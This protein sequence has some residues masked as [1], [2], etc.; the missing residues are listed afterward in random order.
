MGGDTTASLTGLRNGAITLLQKDLHTELLY[1][2][3]RRHEHETVLEG[4]ALHCLGPTK[5]PEE[6]LFKLFKKK[7]RSLDKTRFQTGP[8][9]EYVWEAIDDKRSDVVQFALTQLKVR[10]SLYINITC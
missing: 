1:L 7:W 3:C 8:S 6:P 10:F 9:D 4:A 2:A 5:G